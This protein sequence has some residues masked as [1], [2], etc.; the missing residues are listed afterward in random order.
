MRETVGIPAGILVYF[1]SVIT[2]LIFV[3]VTFAEPSN[4]PTLITVLITITSFKL[5]CA[6]VAN[7][8]NSDGVK[9]V[10]IIIAMFWLLSLGVDIFSDIE[11]FMLFLSGG[12]EVST[13]LE[14]FEALVDSVWNSK[15]CAIISVLLA[16]W[17]LNK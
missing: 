7:F 6:A 2:L 12:N 15:L 10:G 11:K 4:W 17:T 1:V 14:D 16:M 5:T 13:G 3:Q 8:S 9:V